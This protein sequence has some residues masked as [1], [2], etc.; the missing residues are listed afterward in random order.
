ML[1][2]QGMLNLETGWINQF[3]KFLGF[4]NPPNW[5]NDTA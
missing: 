4:Q 1:I 3:L 5:L 2:W